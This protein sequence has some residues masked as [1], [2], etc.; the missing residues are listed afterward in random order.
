MHSTH[1][2]SRHRH[3]EDD[4]DELPLTVSRVDDRRPDSYS[5]SH[6]YSARSETR[7]TSSR[8]S[9]SNSSSRG[10]R[11]TPEDWRTVDA[12]YSSS[13]HDRY[14][15]DGYS[16]SRRDEYFERPEPRSADPWPSRS[17]DEVQYPS[18]SRD[19]T[20][21]GEVGYSSTYTESRSWTVPERYEENGRNGLDDW[22]REDTRKERDKGRYDRDDGYAAAEP[23]WRTSDEGWLDESSRD[24]RAST[25]TER[26]DDRGYWRTSS[27]DRDIEK[28]R[29]PQSI[30]VERDRQ[31]EPAPT[32]R[33]RE[34]DV[35]PSTRTHPPHR[36]SKKLSKIKGKK[37]QQNEP[38]KDKRRD[39]AM[40][41]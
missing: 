12:N 20:K 31:W 36:N 14:R 30:P 10:Q 17:V 26:P 13:N 28:N 18:S 29:D 1:G 25:W 8:L 24:R 2:R 5:R 41:K 11:P 6:N 32:W 16:H 40:N 21:H 7:T 39:D 3:R 4:D 35:E 27:H 33:S 23:S 19:W 22:S 38:K 37:G 15:D 9:Y 34:W